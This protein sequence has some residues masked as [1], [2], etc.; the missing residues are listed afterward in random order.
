VNLQLLR[1]QQNY[2][3]WTARLLSP[4]FWIS[5]RGSL[6][7]QATDDESHSLVIQF[8]L[9]RSQYKAL[10][11]AML[12]RELAL[13]LLLQ[14]EGANKLVAPKDSTNLFPRLYKPFLSLSKFTLVQ[15]LTN[16][17]AII[18][19]TAED[20]NTYYV[21]GMGRAVD[22]K[23]YEDAHLA[24]EDLKTYQTA[25]GVS[26]TVEAYTNVGLNEKEKALLLRAQGAF[27]ARSRA[28]TRTITALRAPGTTTTSPAQR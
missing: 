4:D 18:Q 13:S 24:Y 19:D 27:K 25:M 6:S 8:N 16:G 9:E 7:S 26:K 14:V 5:Y 12:R 2:I 11:N 1:E 28:L 20:P 22:G 3:A 23:M 17:D 21:Y 15:S 10:T